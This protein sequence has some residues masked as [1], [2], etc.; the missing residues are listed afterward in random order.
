MKTVGII[1]GVGPESTIEYYRLIIAAYREQSG[2]GVPPMNHAQDARATN[3]NGSYPSIIINSVDL[4]RLLA[5]LRTGELEAFT[6]YLS[7]EIDRL[8]RAGAD[9]GL[10]ASNTPHLVFDELS[11]RSPIPL[12][13]IVESARDQAQAMNLKRVAL[14]G[15]RFTMQG[16]FYPDVFSRADI[17]VI[18]PQEDEQSYIHEKYM[19]ELLNNIFLP[20]TRAGLLRI[21]DRMKAEDNIE[22]VILGGTEL[23]LIL[24]DSE[25]N[26]IPFLDTTRIHV[27]QIVAALLT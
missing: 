6:D 4:D 21:V 20:E 7:A 8:Y 12:I 1:G 17:A 10:L 13:S 27:K 16:R 18:T 2:M 26:G 25:Y 3:P 5:W 14:F 24:R 19:N 9:F 11:R 23:P 22:A 15:T